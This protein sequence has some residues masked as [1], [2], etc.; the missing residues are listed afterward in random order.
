MNNLLKN[1][2]KKIFL[3]PSVNPAR[4]EPLTILAH[5]QYL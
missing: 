1:R 3:K 5:A 4:I 2:F